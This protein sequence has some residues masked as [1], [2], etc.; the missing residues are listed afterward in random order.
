MSTWTLNFDGSCEP[1]N[2]GG[3]MTAAWILVTDQGERSGCETTARNPSNTN[4]V[5]EWQ[6]L[7]AGIKAAIEQ[8]AMSKCDRLLIRGDSQLVIKQLTG[9]WGSKKEHLTRL[10]DA[11][12][13]LLWDSG[14]PWDAEWVPREKNEKADA[15]GREAYFQAEGRAMPVRQKAW[16]R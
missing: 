4:N 14:I 6:A 5:A 3:R 12:R 7:E 1:T 10:R 13:K 11:V 2:P 9:E 16:A 15:I 8:T